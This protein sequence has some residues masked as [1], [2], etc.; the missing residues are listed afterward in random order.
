MYKDVTTVKHN[1]VVCTV[2][3]K[4]IIRYHI[5]CN[6]CAIETVTNSIDG[7]TDEAD[8]SNNISVKMN[9]SNTKSIH[10]SLRFIALPLDNS[11]AC[12]TKECLIWN[13]DITCNIL[14]IE[15]LLCNDSIYIIAIL[16]NGNIQFIELSLSSW[17]I[18]TIFAIANPFKY[19]SRIFRASILF[20]EACNR[21]FITIN[22]VVYVSSNVL[23]TKGYIEADISLHFVSTGD[24][25]TSDSTGQISVIVRHGKLY[26]AI[27]S[28]TLDVVYDNV[29][30]STKPADK[31]SNV[32][33]ILTCIDCLTNLKTIKYL[34]LS[35]SSDN[36]YELIIG[37]ELVLT[38]AYV[39]VH[40]PHGSLVHL[41]SNIFYIGVNRTLYVCN[42]DGVKYEIKINGE[43]TIKGLLS[44]TDNL[45]QTCLVISLC[46]GA[47]VTYKFPLTYPTS[48]TLIPSE[49]YRSSMR[50]LVT[51]MC[52]IDITTHTTLS[53]IPY[54]M[55]MKN[56]GHNNSLFIDILCYHHDI[57][58][59]VQTIAIS[60]EYNAMNSDPN[61]SES[62]ILTAHSCS[63]GILTNSQNALNITRNK[64]LYSCVDK[65]YYNGLKNEELSYLYLV[66]DGYSHDITDS[67]VLDAI[68]NIN[69]YK[70]YAA[71][72]GNNIEVILSSRIQNI[73]SSMTIP[74]L[75]LNT[76]QSSWTPDNSKLDTIKVD[77]KLITD[78]W[79]VNFYPFTNGYIQICSNKMNVKGRVVPYALLNIPS[80]VDINMSEIIVLQSTH[81]LLLHSQLNKYIYVVSIDT[82]LDG[83][84]LLIETILN[85]D[86]VSSLSQSFSRIA[87][88]IYFGKCNWNNTNL[89]LYAFNEK[90]CETV[91]TIDYSEML[92]SGLDDVVVQHQYLVY[93]QNVSKHSVDI[94]CSSNSGVIFIIRFNTDTRVYR[95]LNVFILSIGI[96]KHISFLTN[97]SMYIN[98]YNTDVI[99]SIDNDSW[100]FEE[101]NI[102]S[103]ENNGQVVCL[104]S[105]SPDKNYMI[106]LQ[107]VENNVVHLQ[108][109]ILNTRATMMNV[110]KRTAIPGRLR[111]MELIHE[112]SYPMLPLFSLVSWSN[113]YGLFNTCNLKC[114]WKVSDPL[115][116]A[117][118]TGLSPSRHLPVPTDITSYIDIFTVHG[119]TNNDS[120]IITSKR[121]SYDNNGFN[122][123]TVYGQYQ[124]YF[125]NDYTKHHL[126]INTS[127]NVANTKSP[128]VL[129]LATSTNML[130]VVGWRLASKVLKLSCLGTISDSNG[131][132]VDMK[133]YRHNSVVYVLVSR[134]ECGIDVYRLSD[135]TS[136]L[137]HI[138]NI[139]VSSCACKAPNISDNSTDIHN[140]DKENYIL[141][142]SKG[143]YVMLTAVDTVINHIIQ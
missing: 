98:G 40:V 79:T 50:P 141:Y 139:V 9:L 61:A 109:G 86:E 71:V 36:K 93:E 120:I 107:Q 13:G 31:G 92:P 85:E 51:S 131:D 63:S 142:I 47:Y 18:K 75:P 54:S 27:R 17:V 62:G 117:A 12:E 112:E 135:T 53:M 46:N 100:H 78:E 116:L 8:S 16:S 66:H 126:Y 118:G 96:V 122:S 41:K 3:F 123:A 82:N 43:G 102:P 81:Y 125:M 95:L 44:F 124:H 59:Q 19:D 49:I 87:D 105:N 22:G 67:Y 39:A 55:Y 58:I 6:C 68:L 64:K 52:G 15:M 33:L 132:I 99:L 14:G 34:E 32:G 30:L 5:N 89:S 21:L 80:I 103:Y 83:A 88:R 38:T 60:S 128:G 138:K 20:V 104:P 2:S 94:V 1:K 127:S 56:L 121:L 42:H 101:V 29:Q 129:V 77:T 111:T 133:Y 90:K 26:K 11:Q 70:I 110:Y 143:Q 137:H 134:V 114:I 106:W 73:S 10:N 57:G 115:L 74:V 130:I 140:Y 113:G 69:Q 37:W 24:H 97:H 65:Y 7:S 48:N 76:K 4:N 28:D 45:Q 136:P 108:M 72:S 119:A 84:I 35:I 25:Y 91:V 23:N